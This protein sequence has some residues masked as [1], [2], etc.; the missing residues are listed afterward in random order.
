MVPATM[1]EQAL[2]FPRQLRAGLAA[3]DAAGSAARL[4]AAAS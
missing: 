1:L 3:G 2:D 4:R